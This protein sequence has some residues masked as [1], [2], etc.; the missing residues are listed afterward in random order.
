MLNCVELSFKIDS[1]TQIST[2]ML[3]AKQFFRCCS[4]SRKPLWSFHREESILP[5]RRSYGDAVMDTQGYF[6]M[7][8]GV[9][10]DILY[11]L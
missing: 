2:T 6:N 1:S 11:L 5:R 3:L 7:S 10:W 9:S 8:A 4:K